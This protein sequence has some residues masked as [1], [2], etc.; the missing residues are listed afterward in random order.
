MSLII[1]VHKGGDVAERIASNR[2]FQSIIQGC[3]FILT[4][5]LASYIPHLVKTNQWFHFIQR[6]THTDDMVVGCLF[7]ATAGFLFVSMIATV[8]ECLPQYFLRFKTQGERSRFTM[9]EWCEAFSLSMFNLL[10]TSWFCL[11]P[12]K[13]ARQWLHDN[14][15]LS[16]QVSHLTDIFSWRTECFKLLLCFI[17]VDIWFYWTHRALHTKFLYKNIHKLHHRFTAPTAVASMYAHP[18]EYGIGNLGG[19]AAGIVLTNCH[20]L[21]AF[22]WT[23]FGVVSS[24]FGHSGYSF[25]GAQNHDYHHQYFSYNFG[26][27][28]G[29]DWLC[30]TSFVGSK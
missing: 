11:L 9:T 15:P 10:F 14:G 26:V 6:M 8:M 20:P 13:W 25:F 21:T 29:M 28:G 16:T 1:S 4:T 19:V 3:H 22:T 7:A 24:T 2:L 5:Q 30:G 17:V 18:L 12:A 27:G 23:G